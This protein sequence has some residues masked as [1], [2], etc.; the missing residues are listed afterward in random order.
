MKTK[1]AHAMKYTSMLL[2]VLLVVGSLGTPLL[3]ADGGGDYS[4]PPAVEDGA[5]ILADGGDD[6]GGR[7]VD[8]GGSAILM[9]DG[10]S[11]HGG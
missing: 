4:A 2:A 7:P 10:G 11:D 9:V 6:L 1:E 3:S 5:V 8:E